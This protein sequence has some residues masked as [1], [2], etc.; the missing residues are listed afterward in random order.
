MQPEC[1]ERVLQRPALTCMRVHVAGCHAIELE[2]PRQPGQPPV[3]GAV[4]GQVG[5]LQLDP[6]ILPAEAVPQPPQCRLVVDAARVTAAQAD[7]ALGVV[8][9]VR[10]GD[11]GGG[12][13]EATPCTSFRVR[14]REQAAEVRPAGCV[15]DQQ[16][17]VAAVIEVELGAMQ[18]AAARAPS[19]SGRTPSSRRPS[20]GRSART[21]CS[22]ARAR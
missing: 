4:P 12:S 11:K 22:R 7:E 3:A 21:P 13:S 16:R 1:D 9:E 20:C 17:Q 19:R 5:T 15:A 10:D 8:E 2:P 18:R 14:A 6:Q